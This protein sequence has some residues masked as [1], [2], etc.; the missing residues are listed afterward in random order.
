MQKLDNK[1]D[2]H[3]DKMYNMDNKI[4]KMA[5]KVDEAH[6]LAKEANKHV[7]D[8]QA[9]VNTFKAELLVVQDLQR[10]LTVKFDT[11]NDGNVDTSMAK[12]IADLKKNVEAAALFDGEIPYNC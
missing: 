4:D 12:D 11:I 2:K 6:G 9:Q 3:S 1:S 7:V 10:D 5:N 8:I